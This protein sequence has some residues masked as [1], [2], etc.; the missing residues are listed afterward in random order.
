MT[1]KQIEKVKEKIVKYKKALSAD[2][3]QWGGF[4]H[5]GNGI[6][7]LIPQLYISI[8]DYKGGLK[9]FN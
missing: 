4:Y 5:D 1:E 3:R 8:M 7:Y 2:K 9:Y 6:R